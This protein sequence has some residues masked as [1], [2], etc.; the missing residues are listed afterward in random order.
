MTWLATAAG[1]AWAGTGAAGGAADTFGFRCWAR[2]SDCCAGVCGFGP[3]LA[4]VVFARGCRTVFGGCVAAAGRASF[5]VTP[6]HQLAAPE[7]SLSRWGV[8]AACEAFGSSPKKACAVSA[9]IIAATHDIRPL[10]DLCSMS[11]WRT[12]HILRNNW[13]VTQN[14][15]SCNG[16]K[17]ARSLFA[18]SHKNR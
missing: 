14:V 2:S 17:H 12:L 9:C 4:V 3:A 1:D 18:A 13:A 7:R 10:V 6:L 15:H 8:G 5:P 16:K 11:F